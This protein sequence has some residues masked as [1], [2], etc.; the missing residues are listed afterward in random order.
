[1]TTQSRTQLTHEAP[2]A[3]Q[4]QGF[5]R[6]YLRQAA[7][8]PLMVGGL[9]LA[10]CDGGADGSNMDH[11]ANKAEPSNANVES[12][13]S[14]T[15][16]D[17]NAATDSAGSGAQPSAPAP[18]PSVGNAP[19]TAGNAGMSDASQPGGA[20]RMEDHPAGL[21]PGQAVVAHGQAATMC[22][23]GNGFGVG[24]IVAGQG[25]PCGV[26]DATAGALFHGHAPSENVRSF[27]PV[28]V[29][30]PA[31]TPGGADSMRCEA[32]AGDGIRCA[33][34]NNPAEHTVYLY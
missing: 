9:F 24:F 17:A 15:A 32:I 34:V 5:S 31:D 23:M 22:R 21:Q 12:T 33:G 25:T 26:A 19:A 10:A 7:L 16:K 28:T 30:L 11:N 6:R 27:V 2:H 18:H 29:T 3:P 13:A 8:V 14:A 20:P 1:M 4:R